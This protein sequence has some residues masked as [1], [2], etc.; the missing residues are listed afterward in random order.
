[1]ADAE[2]QHKRGRLHSENAPSERRDTEGIY[3]E[4][5]NDPF[6]AL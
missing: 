1:M 2:P 6:E 3:P 5:H 4:Q